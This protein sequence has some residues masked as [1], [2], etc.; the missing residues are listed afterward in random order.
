MDAVDLLVFRGRLERSTNDWATRFMTEGEAADARGSLESTAARWAAKEA[1]MKALGIG[2]GQIDPTDIE[3]VKIDDVPTLR[4][5]RGAKNRADELGL[6][7]WSLSL[8]HTPR[9]AIA[10]VVAMGFAHE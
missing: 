10:F 1:A 4:L 8:S 9:L 5:H 2:L 6:T 3:V 7:D